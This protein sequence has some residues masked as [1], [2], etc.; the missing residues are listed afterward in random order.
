MAAGITLDVIEQVANVPDELL[1]DSVASGEFP[2]PDAAR[3]RYVDYLNG[4]SFSA[5]S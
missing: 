4:G 2:S 1:S 5:R 3:N